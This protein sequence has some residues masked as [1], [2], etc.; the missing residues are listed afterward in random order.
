VLGFLYECY[1]IDFPEYL[2]DKKYVRKTLA[3]TNIQIN[4]DVEPK[5]EPNPDS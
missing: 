4:L 1:N 2:L 5:P 3:F